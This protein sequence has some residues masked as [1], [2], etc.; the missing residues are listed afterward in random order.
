MPAMI[1]RSPSSSLDISAKSIRTFDSAVFLRET[2]DY[3]PP[4]PLGERATEL[5]ALVDALNAA[6]DRIARGMTIVELEAL[7]VPEDLLMELRLSVLAGALE[8]EEVIAFLQQVA[9]TVV[10]DALSK[11][12]KRAIR[13]A[14]RGGSMLRRLG[15]GGKCP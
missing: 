15:F 10:G 13:A 8:R 5:Q 6:P 1:M 9:E 7:G 3:T 4:P 12:V 11:A 14:G 2:G